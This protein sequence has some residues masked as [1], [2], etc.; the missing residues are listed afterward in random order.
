[1]WALSSLADRRLRANADDVGPIN[2][3][4]IWILPSWRIINEQSQK[5]HTRCIRS[6]RV[7][8]DGRLMVVHKPLRR[9]VKKNVTCT[10]VA[11]HGWAGHGRHLTSCPNDT[12][13][14][15]DNSSQKL[16]PQGAEN[17]SRELTGP[18]AISNS[19]RLT[20]ARRQRPQEAS[21]STALARGQ[22]ACA[23]SDFV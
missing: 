4:Q 6:A 1:M 12:F 17:S 22:P 2:G 18:E 15:T 8:I 20:N 9:R 10:A 13:S 19:Q 14:D 21:V 16:S 11:A 23:R 7:S 3:D 5:L